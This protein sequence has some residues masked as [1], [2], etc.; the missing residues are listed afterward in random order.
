MRVFSTDGNAP[1]SI[2][3]RLGVQVGWVTTQSA[4][5]TPAAAMRS[6]F[7]VR[8]TGLPYADRVSARSSSATISRIFGG[9]GMGPLF[10]EQ[11][12]RS[13]GSRCMS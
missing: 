8:H 5:R 11:V 10:V 1:V 13:A 4:N 7:G 3:A 9:F 6:R 12:W 2:D